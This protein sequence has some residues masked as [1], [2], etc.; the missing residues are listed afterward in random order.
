VLAEGK[1]A[2]WELEEEGIAAISK[3]FGD[4]VLMQISIRK[5]R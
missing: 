5:E 2:H 4:R 1:K 3:Y